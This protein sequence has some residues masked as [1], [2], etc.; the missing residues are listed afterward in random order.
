MMINMRIVATLMSLFSLEDERGRTELVFLITRYINILK[1]MRI[2]KGIRLSVM[3]T[4]VETL[5]IIRKV[6][7]VSAT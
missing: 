7:I 1:R 5:N 2:T 4:N 6:R 3:D